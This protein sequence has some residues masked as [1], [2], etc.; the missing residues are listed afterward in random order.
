MKALLFYLL[1]VTSAVPEVSLLRTPN[2][3]IPPQAVVDKAGRI[4]V[5]YFKGAARAG[6]LFYVRKE[7]EFSQ[8]IQ[9]NSKAASAIA[10]GTIRGAQI[11]LGKNGRIHVAWN[12]ADGREMLY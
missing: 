4:H 1:A 12:S 5:V 11:A 2:D 7:A 3:G 10:V 8:P 9:V 6:D